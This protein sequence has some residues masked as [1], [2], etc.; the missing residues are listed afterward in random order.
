M[1]PDCKIT[2]IFFMCDE[3][4]KNF[5][6]IVSIFSITEGHCDKKRK[7]HRDGKMSVSEVMTTKAVLS[8]RRLKNLFFRLVPLLLFFSKDDLVDLKSFCIFPL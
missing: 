3:F 1:F 2:E 6:E 8:D 4:S 7:Y 5:D